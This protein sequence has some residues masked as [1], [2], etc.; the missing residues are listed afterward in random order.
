MKYILEQRGYRIS[1]ASNGKEA[2][3]LMIE[4]KPKL[5]IS[6]VIMPE[7]DGYELCQQIKMDENLKNIPIILLTILPEPSDIIKGLKCKA[8]HFVTKPYDEN[9]LLARIQYVLS[10]WEMH[11]KQEIEIGMEILIGGQKYFINPDRLQIL[12]LLIS[13]YEAAVQ[14]NQELIKTRD[15]LK[16]L[17]E[18]LEEKVEERTTSLN[19]E[20]AEHIRAEEKLLAYQKQLQSLTSQLSLAEE[21]ER[22]R[23]AIDLHDHIGQTLALCKIKLGALRESVSSAL[24]V[25][26][27][28]IR[29]L[30]DQTIQYTRS[31][32]SELSPPI[33]YEFGF[34]AAVDWLGEQILSRQ[35][36][37]FHFNDDRQPKPMEDETRVLLFQAVRELL[38]NVAKHSQAR[39]SSVYIRRDGN[40]IQINVED[41]GVGLDTSK[42]NSYLRTE[43]F[44]LF[45][46]RERLNCI[47]GHLNIKSGPGKG[48]KV[49]IIVPLK[50]EK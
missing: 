2:L 39:N 30:I 31:L 18:H 44:G 5:V 16:R 42:S 3:A 14:Q 6:D 47:R 32:T 37:H 4:H 27:D 28:G 48:T 40:N 8:D 13:T 49:T 34:E 23:L 9:Y 21:R 33:L 36:I 7:M 41:D 15:E 22:H 1:V 19:A 24:V 38:V 17:N 46:I 35:D 11:E 12:H 50:L 26:V 43:S 45:S 20:I 25:S 10:N 29:D